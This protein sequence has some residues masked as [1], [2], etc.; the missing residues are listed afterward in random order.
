MPT[1]LVAGNWKM[2]TTVTEAE[3]LAASLRRELD[4]LP[5]VEVALCPPFVS[6]ERVA[7]A[8]EGSSLKVGAQNM[9]H[10]DKGAFTG[11]VSPTMLQGMCQIVIL[12]HSERRNLF[13]ETDELVNRK[14]RKALEVGLRPILCV[15]ERLEE[16][17]QGREEAVVSQ[18][19][20]ACLDGVASPDGLPHGMVVAYEPVWAIGTGLAATGEQAQAMSALIRRLLA[21]RYGRQG[22]EAVPVL[23]GGSVTPANVAEFVSQ[24]D[25]DGALVGGASLDA[26]QFAE[27][28]RITAKTRS[29]P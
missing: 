6:L 14:V 1:P 19:L 18:S 9:H 12:G 26:Q 2:N 5:G 10:E 3:T 4:G 29:S 20:S 11:E 17:Q 15:G 21:D 23:Y 16:R 22:A 28:V 24:P 13:G 7:R 8:L 25:I 27:I